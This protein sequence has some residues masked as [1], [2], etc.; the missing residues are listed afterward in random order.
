[1]TGETYRIIECTKPSE[2][3]DLTDKQKD[4]YR[5]I[6][7]AVYVNISEGSRVHK[8]L[9]DMFPEGTTTGDA[10]RDPANGLT[11]LPNLPNPE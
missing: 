3:N 1:M 7:S 4:W 10:I 11:M 6:I 8:H 9:W 2:F 5:M